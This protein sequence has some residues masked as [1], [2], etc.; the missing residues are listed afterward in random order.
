MDFVEGLPR[1]G[2]Y[3]CILVVVDKFSK[4]SHFIPLRHPFTALS[5]A[6]AF[7]DNVYK[8]HRMPASIVSDRDRVFTSNVWKELFGLAGVSLKMSS[9]YHSRTDGQTECVNQCMRHTCAAP[10]TH[11]RLNGQV[12]CHWPSSGTIPACTLPWVAHLLRYCMVTPHITL[13]FIL[14]QPYLIRTYLGGY[15][16]ALS[17]KPWLCNT[18]TEPRNA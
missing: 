5:V 12:G 15:K 18:S 3:N 17:C 16:S 13:A 6:K 7:L 8:L 9:L 4:F 1:S 2:H 14:L 10:S 11:A